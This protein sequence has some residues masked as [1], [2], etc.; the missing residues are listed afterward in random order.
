MTRPSITYATGDLLAANTQALV[1]T[2]NCVGVMGKGLAQQ[3]K[4]RF[5][6][7]FAAYRMACKR[8]AVTIG[9]MFVTEI[10][11]N[12]RYII[13]FP[14]KNHWQ[15]PSTLAYIEAGLVDLA[16]VICAHNI[17]SIA[18]PPLGAGLGGLNWNDVHPRITKAFVDLPQVNVIIYPPT[19]KRASKIQSL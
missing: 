16:R 12:H 4:Q 14:T 2:V 11:E 3:F 6:D 17:E 8:R 1:N 15:Q 5:P 13:N 18:I 7:N 19:A 10:P 9:S